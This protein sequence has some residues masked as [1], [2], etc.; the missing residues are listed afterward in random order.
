MIQTERMSE[1]VSG[2]RMVKKLAGSGDG[3]QTT[4]ILDGSCDARRVANLLITDI[5]YGEIDILCCIK[6]VVDFAPDSAK[7]I[8]VVIIGV[9][10][11]AIDSV[12]HCLPTVIGF[13][14]ECSSS[15]AVVF[16]LVR[17][18]TRGHL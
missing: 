10:K 2:K 1:F 12:Y 11:L 16:H 13:D 15:G 5:Y 14:I 6:L 17:R 4:P 9:G 18:K 3:C 8:V 7:S